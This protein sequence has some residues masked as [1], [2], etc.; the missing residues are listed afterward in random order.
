MAVRFNDLRNGDLIVWRNGIQKT[1]ALSYLNVVRILT[2][3]DFGHV[4][5]VWN[6]NNDIKHIEAAMPKVVH[7]NLPLKANLYVVPIGRE[8]SNDA[9]SDFFTPQIGWKY[10]IRDA[11]YGL[12][13]FIPKEDN[14]VQC[15]EQATDFYKSLGMNLT[16]SYTPTK[17]VRRLM[18]NEGLCLQKIVA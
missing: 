1:G 12:L 6:S 7:T 16:N 2:L 15:A 4:S 9:M 10:S 5:V 17:L 14:R 18:E 8:I 13:G 3:S 11:T